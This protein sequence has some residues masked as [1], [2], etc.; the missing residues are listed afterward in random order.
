MKTFVPAASLALLLAACGG[1]DTDTTST[2]A[3]APLAMR[4]GDAMP[5]AAEYTQLTQSLYVG[6]FGRPADVSGL[7]YWSKIFSA[8]VLPQDFPAWIAGYGVNPDITSVLDAM[9]NSVESQDLYV[10]NNASY[11]NAVYANGFNRYAEAS[12]REFWGGLID[13]RTITRAQAVLSIFGG[14][15][16]GDAQIL[17]KK[18]QA[19]AIFT[20][21]LS[22]PGNES[23]RVAYASGNYSDGARELLGRI[24]ATTDME[25]FRAEIAAFV[26][27]MTAGSL[28]VRR[29]VGYH[30][31]QDV[32]NQPLYAAGFS[33]EPGAYWIPSWL[34][35]SGKLTYGA[36]L[37]TI[38]W[39]RS[40][41]AGYIYGAPVTSSA[42][43][44]ASDKL[45][46]MIM[47]CSPVVTAAG[48]VTKSTDVLVLRKATRLTDAAQLANQRFT[49]YRENCATG[50]SNLSSFSFDAS[51]NGSFP[52]G[53]GVMLIDTAGVNQILNGQV[54]PDISTGKLLAFSA[55]SY[56]RL[57]GS[58]GFLI[59]QHLGNRKT[60]VTDGV[61][62]VWAQE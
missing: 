7:E 10:S 9:V 49:V 15:Q 33:Y 6:F 57:D 48:T 5:T 53:S 17:V 2:P 31:L 55:Y 19:A 47:L 61:V 50:G 21:L 35:G 37:Q 58:T 46:A 14:A 12:G 41:E 8:K 29:Y 3:R 36:D 51:G 38:T 42:K 34:P 18:A 40:D 59:V 22:G 45:P 44:L 43:L 16:G 60:G 30:Y 13:R 20:N 4:S 28:V 56:Q 54:L 27:Q 52:V 23:L 1:A 11:I 32:T 62:A 25:V 26:S 24:T 39:T